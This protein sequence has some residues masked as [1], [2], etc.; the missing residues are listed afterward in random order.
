MAAMDSVFYNKIG[1][2]PIQDGTQTIGTKLYLN[3]LIFSN[4]HIIIKQNRE[5]YMLQSSF[6]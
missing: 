5:K 4:N 2:N 3:I 6:H 1:F